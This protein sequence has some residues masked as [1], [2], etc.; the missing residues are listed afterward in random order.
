MVT[1]VKINPP[2][3]DVVFDSGHTCFFSGHITPY[4]V[5]RLRNYEKLLTELNV[6]WSTVGVLPD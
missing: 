6:V 3:L 1:D 4:Q 2:V 5:V